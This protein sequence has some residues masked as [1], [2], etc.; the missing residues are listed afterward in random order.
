M[1][2]DDDQ[3]VIML[4]I[5]Y[6]KYSRISVFV[7]ELDNDEKRTVNMSVVIMST[8]LSRTFVRF[9]FSIANNSCF[10]FDV[11]LEFLDTQ[12]NHRVV[13]KFR[14]LIDEAQKII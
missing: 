13:F 8:I 2:V 3:G 1:S 7:S 9:S 10:A 5:S 11:Q 12:Q 14:M 6:F 4:R